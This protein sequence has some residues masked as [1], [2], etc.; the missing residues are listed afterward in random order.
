MNTRPEFDSD[1]QRSALWN[2][3]VAYLS[4]GQTPVDG[5]TQP[6]DNAPQQVR[7]VAR[8]VQSK[9]GVLRTWGNFR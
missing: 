3:L 1:A 6:S 5:I 9:L 8:D 7:A 2:A 4:P